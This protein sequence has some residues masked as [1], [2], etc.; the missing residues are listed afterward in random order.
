MFSFTPD[1]FVIVLLYIFFIPMFLICTKLHLVILVLGC[2]Y[3]YW[4][5]K[6]FVNVIFFFLIWSFLTYLTFIFV[7][8]CVS[9][10]FL[11]GYDPITLMSFIVWD[12]SF[13]VPRA[14]FD[15][16]AVDGGLLLHSIGGE[17]FNWDN[18]RMIDFLISK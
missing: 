1:L 17:D 11:Q 7:E 15:V 5:K 16:D 10:Y 6:S 12:N 9:Q 4:V 8:V 18:D 14:R 2:V 13:T 3:I